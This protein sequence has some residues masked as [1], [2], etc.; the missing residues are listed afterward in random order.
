MRFCWPACLG[1]F[2][3]EL[4]AGAPPDS[5]SEMFDH[6]KSFLALLFLCMFC[7]TG[8]CDFEITSVFRSPEQYT[9]RQRM[10]LDENLD[11]AERLWESVIL[12]HQGS[13]EDVE[14]LLTIVPQ[15]VG[16]ASATGTH[17]QEIDGRIM[18]TRGI[19]YINV[20]E[21]ENVAEGLGNPGVSILDELL[22]HEIG[23]A[24]GIG[25]LW[26]TNSLYVTDSGEYRGEHALAAYQA[27]FDPA[28]TFV[29]VEL[30]GSPDSRNGHWNQVFR[31][32]PQ[33]G[34]PADPYSLSP[35]IGITDA[36][37]RDFAQ[38]VMSA[39]LDAD[40]GEPFLSNT[41][42]QAMR[43]L[44][45]ETVS[46][47]PFAGDADG[48]GFVEVGDADAIARMVGDGVNNPVYDIDGDASVG[49]ADRDYLVR[50]ILDL[51]YGD[52]NLD[53]EFDS[54]DLVLVSQAAQYRNDVVGDSVWS[55]GDWDG[56][57]EF[58]TGD[59]MLAFRA[60]TYERPKLHA[61]PE[62]AGTSSVI[63]LLTGLLMISRSG[64]V[65][66]E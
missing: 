23:H 12:G 49:I 39:A 46:S 54:A 45:F 29:P 42:V 48:D 13:D 27:E 14:F 11:R 2:I 31:S 21:I 57:L 62:S 35:L 1:W 64:K 26:T 33:E 18:A 47:F 61:V 9:D 25:T 40:Y 34:N 52:A 19:M 53:G 10:V 15:R 20:N 66:P 5:E 50:E 65:R 41:T 60:G 6:C 22:V 37:G 4:D 56:D 36:R 55:T 43:D 3:L 63:A 30:A 28:A 17:F 24:L 58:D 7:S 38:E 44:G 8:S 51:S 32:S 16:L 59:L